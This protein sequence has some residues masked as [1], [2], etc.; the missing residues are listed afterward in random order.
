MLLEIEEIWLTLNINTENGLKD[1]LMEHTEKIISDSS[2][3]GQTEAQQ[4]KSFAGFQ[5]KVKNLY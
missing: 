5:K 1:Q 2:A 4:N 3:K